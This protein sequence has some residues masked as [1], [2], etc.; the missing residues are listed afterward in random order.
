MKLWK[1]LKTGFT[2]PFTLS[3]RFRLRVWEE[4]LGQQC[5]ALLNP[6]S[7]QAN[8]LLIKVWKIFTVWNSLKS[9]RGYCLSL[10]TNTVAHRALNGFS[11]YTVLYKIVP[12]LLSSYHSLYSFNYILG[13]VNCAVADTRLS[14]EQSPPPKSLIFNLFFTCV[15]TIV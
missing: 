15:L 13:R 14:K 10:F 1:F 2:S 3:P 7:R 11:M 4:H 8:I 9:F 12:S 5:P 6:H